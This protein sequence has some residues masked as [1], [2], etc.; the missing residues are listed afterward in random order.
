MKTRIRPIILLAFL[1]AASAVVLHHNPAPR[2]AIVPS[3]VAVSQAP[4]LATYGK[5]PLAFEANQGQTDAQVKFLSRGS[6]YTLYLTSDEAVLTLRSG[7]PKAKGKGQKAEVAER[8]VPEVHGPL[9]SGPDFVLPAGNLGPL[10][11]HNLQSSIGNSRAPS[12]ESVVPSREPRIATPES[13]TDAVLRMRLV[14]ANPAARVVGAES[15]P[16]KSNYFLGKDSTKWRT[17][18]ANY[19][20]VEY[21]GVYPGIDLVYY[22]NQGRLEHDFVVS[23]GAD[24]TAI[25]LA[26]E[27][28][29]SLR[30]DEQGNLVAQLDAGY[31]VLT[32]PALY[33][34]GNPKSKIRNQKSVDGR[35]VLL[36][37]NRV[38]FE[39]SNYDKNQ[40]LVI[41]PVLS[42]S[43]YL[44][45]DAYDL[46]ASMAVDA[47]GNAY[48]AG[49]TNSTNFPTSMGGYREAPYGGFDAFVTKVNPT[50]SAVVYSTYLGGGA[51]DDGAFGVAVDALG[52]AYLAG[53][54]DNSNFPITPGAFQTTFGGNMDG[55]VTKL[56]ATGST[57]VYST[58]LGGSWFDAA[59]A[60][61]VHA[62]GSVFVVGATESPDFPLANAYQ[63]TFYPAEVA[64]VTRL[65]PT[66]TALEYSTYLGG[67]GDN[68][69]GAVAVDSAGN[70]YVA[71]Y[72]QSAD[73]PT[74]PGA[75]DRT[76]G[77]DGLCNNH[78]Y[79]S[80]V[81]KLDP[82]GAGLLYSTYL[83]GSGF[84]DGTL[85]L[86]VDVHGNA[87]V[88]GN[89]NSTDFPTT[90]GSF[91]PTCANCINYRDGY[92]VKLNPA[93][94]SL[95]YSTYLGGSGFDHI[96]AIAADASGRVTVGGRTES[97]DFPLASPIQSVFGG[98]PDDGFIARLNSSG[99]A[100]EFSTLLG[101]NE[102]DT[103]SGVVVD[104]VGNTYVTGYAVSTNFPTQ[105]P[106]QDSNQGAADSFLVK[107]PKSSTWPAIAVTPAS[108]DFG[109]LLV[110]TTSGV[111]TATLTNTGGAALS[112]SGIAVN[113][114]HADDFAQ[115]NNCGSVLPAGANCTINVTF[116][117]LMTGDCS[118]A[119]SI[120]HGAEGSP[121]TVTLTGHGTD[122]SM[123]AAADSAT[124]AVIDAGKTAHYRL[125][126]APEGGFVGTVSL[127]VCC[128]RDLMD[129]DIN[130]SEITVN[131]NDP[132]SFT[133]D[134]TTYARDYDSTR[135]IGPPPAWP[136]GL[137]AV[138][139]L[140]A[141][142]T[143]AGVAGV[144]KRRSRWALAAAL[145]ILLSSAACGGGMFYNTM[146]YGTTPGTYSLTVT[147]TSGVVSHSLP[148]TLE[149]R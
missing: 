15:L 142:V 126:V 74:T 107:I 48:L 80:F 60:V 63:P 4:I 132:A 116:K 120:T 26:I 103:V 46:A 27:G 42:Y 40:S 33:Q 85:R 16:G 49:Y 82:T 32:K 62:S 148:L 17:G 76:C 56:D 79:D 75:F 35:F 123:A 12:A 11:I 64:F 130:P 36:A 128:E 125:L 24:P 90:L 98:I 139:A 28:A 95:I 133:V 102:S 99:S 9:A 145:L 113:G 37:G 147:A 105:D 45:G 144:A 44:G 67:S 65:N 41:D 39:V 77:T 66:G 54:T 81:T 115:T 78:S 71:G 13:R 10:S 34:L 137:V 21:K 84:E 14:G 31:V 96:E 92:V 122:F 19:A 50:G 38:G 88:S 134:V 25:N 108:M 59:L 7:S 43:S 58:F 121:H 70:A 18:V 140:M 55:F 100:L 119:L 20:T 1:F 61:A 3:G 136:R 101:G 138:L 53:L 68:G 135:L 86:A 124:T 57:L 143:C 111:H 131:G 114:E 112:I 104:S 30:L 6:G 5:P 117:P 129:T 141:L 23:P 149:V 91:D 51:L 97:T 47:A 22:G 118:A 73:F 72:V 69:A 94:S 127:K 110:T 146:D 8:T 52:N 89:T 87:Y 29:D 106:F 109:Y 2:P 83:G 93:G